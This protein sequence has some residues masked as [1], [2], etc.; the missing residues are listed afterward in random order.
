[1]KLFILGHTQH[2]KDTAANLVGDL[3]GMR[4]TSSS[5]FACRRFIWPRLQQVEPGRYTNSLE[6]HADRFNRRDEWFQ[7][8]KQHN[9]KDPSRL[10]REIFEQFDIYVGMR[11]ITEFNAA[12][13][14]ADLSIWIDASERKPPESTDSM[15]IEKRHAD[16]I[17][18]NN[19]TEHDLRRRLSRICNALDLTESY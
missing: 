18:D 11:D 4:W 15:T 2:G 5:W 13:H 16:M 8:I 17:V 14:L 10:A 12:N 7:W 9:A 19:G 1:M 3:T 6:C